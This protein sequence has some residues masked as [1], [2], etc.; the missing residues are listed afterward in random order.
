MAAVSIPT[1]VPLRPSLRLVSLPEL[2]AVSP[3]VW[4]AISHRSVRRAI[5]VAGLIGLACLVWTLAFRTLPSDQSFRG[6]VPSEVVVSAGDSLWSIAQDLDLDQD[7]RV[8]VNE[9]AEANGGTTLVVGQRVV[10]PA[11]LRGG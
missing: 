9:L 7:I 6:E 4:S 8:T 3:D 2:D 5:V 11:V 1:S 10:I